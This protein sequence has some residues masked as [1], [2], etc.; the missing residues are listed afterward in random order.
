MDDLNGTGSAAMPTSIARTFLLIDKEGTKFTYRRDLNHY[1]YCG[2]YWNL[3][4]YID[5]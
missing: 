1:K 5:A 3:M 4:N 2:E